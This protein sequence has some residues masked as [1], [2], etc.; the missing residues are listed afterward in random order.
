[1]NVGYMI[2]GS[3]LNLCEKIKVT[4]APHRSD[5][6]KVEFINSLIKLFIT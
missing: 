4:Y 6:K 5:V 1:M 2:G 3:N